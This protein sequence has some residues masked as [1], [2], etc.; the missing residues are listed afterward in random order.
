MNT[1]RK[2]REVE[3]D[4]VENLF[5]KGVL[6]YEHQMSRLRVYKENGANMYE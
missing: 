2:L 4:E 3:S 1:I 6:I 5:K